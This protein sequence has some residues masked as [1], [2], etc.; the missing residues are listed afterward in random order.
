MVAVVSD[1]A[2]MVLGVLEV[3]GLVGL[4]VYVRVQARRRAAGKQRPARAVRISVALLGLLVAVAFPALMI[5]AIVG[6]ATRADRERAE[7]VQSG[8]P[9]TGV[10]TEIEETGNVINRRPE[11]RV[12]VTVEPPGAPSFTSEATWTFSVKDVQTYRVGTEVKVFFDPTDH[13]A[14]AIVGVTG[15]GR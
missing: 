1:L 6:Q 7:L 10:I 13:G 9:A 14:I 4:F 11:V 8:T 3:L 5:M 12:H 2:L 15:A